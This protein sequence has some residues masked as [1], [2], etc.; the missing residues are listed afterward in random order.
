VEFLSPLEL[1][2][3][4]DSIARW[5]IDP[6]CV[7]QVGMRTRWMTLILYGSPSSNARM[8]SMSGS[9]LQTRC[10]STLLSHGSLSLLPPPRLFV[11]SVLRPQASM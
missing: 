8:P 3:T 5:S 7:P 11:D 4:F 9:A 10:C 2:R 1:V 6:P